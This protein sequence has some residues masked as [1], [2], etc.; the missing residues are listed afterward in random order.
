MQASTSIFF[1]VSLFL[2]KYE[3]CNTFNYHYIYPAIYK[4][5]FCNWYV[6][7]ALENESIV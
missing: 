5:I 4:T 6:L 1:F 3:I 7:H 2:I